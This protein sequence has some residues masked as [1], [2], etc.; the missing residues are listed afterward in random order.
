M[1]RLI[2]GLV[3]IIPTLIAG[4]GSTPDDTAEAAWESDPRVGEEVTQVC[5]TRE[6]SS[7]QNVDNDRYALIL[8]MIN[9]DT[10]KVKLMGTCDPDMATSRIAVIS[11]PGTSCFSR[12]DRIRTDGDLSR[13]YGSACTISRIY[14][15]NPAA[16]NQA[17]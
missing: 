15:W 16:L 8:K 14:K 11:R 13:D 10:Y 4:C 17:E 6:V 5:F 1:K 2:S 7:W 12:G 9:K 3:I